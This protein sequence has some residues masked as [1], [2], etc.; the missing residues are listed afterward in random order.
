MKIAIAQ[1]APVFLDRGRTI[2]K[3]AASVRDAAAKHAALACFGET[4]IPAYPFWLSRTDGAR[5][6][7][8]DQKELHARYL[9]QAVNIERGDL[10][11]LREA[12]RAGNIAVVVGIAERPDNRGQTIYCSRVFIN[13]RGEV[14]SVHRK[15]MPTYEER[16]AWGIGDG[17]GLITHR[18]GEF[19]LGALNCWENWMP[20]A[21]AALYAQ[22]ED[23]HVALWPGCRRLTGDITRF[24]ARESRSYVVS[25]SVLLREQDIPPDFP[26]R[27]R[28]CPTAGEHIYDGGSCIAAP[29]GSWLVE[30]V[31]N[32]EEIIYADI[33]HALVR[34]ERQNFDPSGHYARP[35]ILRLIVDRRRQATAEF[36]DG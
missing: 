15:L 22:G 18:L 8:A 35:D 17:A 36:I 1:I 30:P 13:A 19:T 32:R 11:P 34:R 24:I 16:L 9:D 12:A 26:D 23:L 29:D 3:A 33:D 31:V 28:C 7:A 6:D 4:L 27:S 5:F 10:D 14:A 25:A 21:R 20:L 2:A